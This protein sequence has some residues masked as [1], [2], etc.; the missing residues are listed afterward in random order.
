M[1]AHVFL[2]H[3]MR[4]R[5]RVRRVVTPINQTARGDAEQAEIDSSGA[6]RSC[7]SPAAGALIPHAAQVATSLCIPTVRGAARVLSCVRCMQ[8]ATQGCAR[9]GRRLLHVQSGVF[10]TDLRGAPF[11]GGLTFSFASSTA[12]IS[13]AELVLR[14]ANGYI[15]NYCSLCWLA[16]AAL[17]LWRVSECMGLLSGVVS[18]ISCKHLLCDLE[19]LTYIH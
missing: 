19:H 2:A 16:R 18:Q 7:S 13:V 15:M 4:S 3:A 14:L 5:T 17:S 11:K 9:A 6:A 1:C 12:A 8:C 10:S